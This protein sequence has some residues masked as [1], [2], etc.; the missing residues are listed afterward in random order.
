MP[1]LSAS[2]CEGE[3]DRQPGDL[4]GAVREDG[5]SGEARGAHHNRDS[6]KDGFDR[7]SFETG[8]LSALILSA[9]GW[10]LVLL[11]LAGCSPRIVET[12]RTEYV[13]QDR[14]ERDTTIVHD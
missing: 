7:E 3:A 6:M 11:I 5:R 8:C 10:M 2:L 4:R 13:Y 1:T 14:I 9:L 12:V